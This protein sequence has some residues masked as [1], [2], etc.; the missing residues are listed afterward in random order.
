MRLDND[1]PY[2]EKRPKSPS[3]RRGKGQAGTFTI[4]AMKHIIHGERRFSAVYFNRDDGLE[5][6][7]RPPFLFYTAL[8]E[9]DGVHAL[10]RLARSCAVESGHRP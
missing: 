9:E 3:S 1:D 4:E 10:L 8:A 2:A 5:P 6:V 7:V